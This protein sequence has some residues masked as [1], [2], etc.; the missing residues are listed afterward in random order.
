[1]KGKTA[2]TI[3]SEIEVPSVSGQMGGRLVPGLEDAG[4][5][6]AI[7]DHGLRHVLI[8]VEEGQKP[9]KWGGTRGLEVVVE[10]LQV[11]DR[12]PQLYI[13]V[14]C[15]DTSM[16]ENFSGLAKE[17]CDGLVADRDNV[18]PVLESIL[19]RWRWFWGNLPQDLSEELAVGLFGEL[20]FLEYWMKPI[21]A[22]VLRTWS[23]PARD[24]HD[25][26]WPAASVEIKSTRVRTDGAAKHR[27]SNLDQLEDPEE[28]DLH[29][30]SLRVTDDPIGLHSL[31][32][33]VDRI[34]ADL[35]ADPALLHEFDEHLVQYGYTPAEETHSQR[36]LRVVAEELYRVEEGFPRLIRGTFLNGVPN[37]V[38][39]INYTL[40]LAAC[41][42]WR[43]A[44]APGSESEH[45][46][47]SL[48]SHPGRSSRPGS[49]RAGSRRPP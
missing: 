5:L 15:R 39:G 25:F 8:E 24:R 29:L 44:T 30:F 47:A 45:L 2:A 22:D 26:K 20:W 14:S 32:A 1:M 42:P 18:R 19:E 35:A 4:V 16:N 13:D 10:E 38:D 41:E 46:R 36:R 6:L 28:G 23:G 40:D 37:G 21:T 34:R 48:S 11:A 3:W 43:V 49:V 12:P 31:S 27:I 33:S 9:P 17:I 7:D